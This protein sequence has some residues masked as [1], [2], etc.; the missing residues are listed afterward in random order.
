M[1]PHLL[2]SVHLLKFS[3]RSSSKPYAKW[4]LLFPRSSATIASVENV[5]PNKGYLLGYSTTSKAFRVYNK[6]T[7]RVEENPHI[8]FLEDQPNVTGTGPNWMFDLNFLTNSMNYIPVSVENQ[9]NV[10]AGIPCSDIWLGTDV[11]VEK[12]RFKDQLDRLSAQSVGSSNTDVLD[13]P[14]LAVHYRNVQS[15]HTVSVERNPNGWEGLCIASLAVLSAGGT[16]FGTSFELDSS[17]ACGRE[18]QF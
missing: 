18:F 1:H 4:C 7:K 5:I 10:D 15:N 11:P 2:S 3:K 13:L 8:N 12:V 16:T 6:R 9:V 17:L 14:M